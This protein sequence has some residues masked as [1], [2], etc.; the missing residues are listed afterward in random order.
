LANGATRTYSG[1]FDACD[2][3][4]HI[5]IKEAIASVKL[6]QLSNMRDC[7]LTLH[8]DSM[9]VH[10][11]L[12]SYYT[13]HLAF[14]VPL[15][16]AVVWQC[17]NNVTMTVKYVAS[18]D[19]P[20]DAPSRSV[21]QRT[22]DSSDYSLENGVYESVLRWADMVGKIT[23]DMCAS[24][25]N[26]V[27]SNFI[28]RMESGSTRQRGVDCLAVTA[29]ATDESGKRHTLWVFP[30]WA[31]LSAV[32]SHLQA[33]GAR[34]II[35]APRDVVYN[36]VFE[37]MRARAVRYTKIGSAGQTGVLRNPVGPVTLRTDLFAMLF[38]FTDL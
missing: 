16:M 20:A 15:R 28:A 4:R 3:P 26:T 5:N 9:A 27:V 36:Q 10:G 17:E 11:A 24:R 18:A 37:Y 33:T 23:L 31:I 1:I 14:R 12:T 38:D 32:W 34:G 22:S 35:L 25:E 2:Q 19:N 30:P 13:R 8:V 29:L 7:H 21:R 6:L